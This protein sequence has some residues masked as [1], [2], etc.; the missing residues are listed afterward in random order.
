MQ[1]RLWPR[2]CAQSCI[3]V[4]QFEAQGGDMRPGNTPAHT[5]PLAGALVTLAASSRSNSEQLGPP[6]A[7][8][9]SA[10]A[11]QRQTAGGTWVTIPS[12]ASSSGDELLRLAATL[13]HVPVPN[14]SVPDAALP[15]A[16]PDMGGGRVNVTG[17]F[18]T[19]QQQRGRRDQ[20]WP[21]PSELRMAA[22]RV[23]RGGS[24]ISC[25]RQ[26]LRPIA[27]PS[28]RAG[29]GRLERRPAGSGP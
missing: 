1:T 20:Q 7:L 13:H 18:A 29:P 17:H 26:A 22:A 3:Y 28:K 23:G 19:V 25:A 14:A 6:A 15:S 24:R 9:G 8:T 10:L 4:Q 5:S 2:T 11:C 12:H 21:S 27:A 16:H